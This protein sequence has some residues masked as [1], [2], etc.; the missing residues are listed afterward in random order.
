MKMTHS[1]MNLNSFVGEKVI[2]TNGFFC[3]TPWISHGG[4]PLKSENSD[5]K[6]GTYEIVRVTPLTDEEG[7]AKSYEVKRIGDE[8]MVSRDY[9]GS[10]FVDHKIA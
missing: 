1:M 5:M 9:M 7:S 4:M 6:D 2:V 8:V 3:V 10:R